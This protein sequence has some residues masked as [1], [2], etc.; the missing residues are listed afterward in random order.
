MALSRIPP[1]PELQAALQQAWN[2]DVC[3]QAGAAALS[4]ADFLISWGLAGEK[5]KQA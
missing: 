5:V 4:G 3:G 1:L 2:T